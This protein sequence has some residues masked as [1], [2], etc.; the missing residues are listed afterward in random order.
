MC[1][2]TTTANKLFVIQ[3][4]W[5]RFYPTSLVHLARLSYVSGNFVAERVPNI[6]PTLS[7]LYNSSLRNNTHILKIVAVTYN[8]S[9]FHF[10]GWFWRS[11]IVHIINPIISIIVIGE[12]RF[13]QHGRF[14]N[15]LKLMCQEVLWG[16]NL[17][18]TRTE[19]IY[20]I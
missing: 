17:L 10:E 7:H 4:T 15:I 3:M 18:N 16:V 12:Y 11:L 19:S 1:I 9:I 14:I 13:S 6:L 5:V 8:G 20:F 2:W